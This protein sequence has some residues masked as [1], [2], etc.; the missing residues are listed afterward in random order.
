MT[1][2]LRV[3]LA[4][5]IACG[6]CELACAFAHAETSAPEQPRIHVARRGPEAGSPLVCFQCEDPS[7]A[8][9]CP[10]GA[11]RRSGTTGAIEVDAARCIRCRACVS[12]CP[13][14]SMAW[15]DGSRR[16]QKCDLCGGTPRCV[17]FCPTAAL[18][19]LPAERARP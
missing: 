11:L 6:K 10:T 14:G 2:V 3:T 12:A 4:R 19:Y 1:M 17:P 18:E 16:P 9:A 13:F 7:C 8:A 15:D 5:C